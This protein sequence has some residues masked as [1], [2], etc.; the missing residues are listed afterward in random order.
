MWFLVVC[1][2]SFLYK[3]CEYHCV[4]C[5]EARWCQRWLQRA[6]D[7]TAWLLARRGAPLKQ[8]G[9]STHMDLVSFPASLNE[10]EQRGAQ[11]CPQCSQSCVCGV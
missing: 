2:T 9:F 6:E 1:G 7:G 3:M 4:V 10:A 11:G 5:W 8:L